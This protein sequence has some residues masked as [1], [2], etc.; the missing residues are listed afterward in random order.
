[1]VAIMLTLNQI[2][3]YILFFYMNLH[4]KVRPNARIMVRLMAPSKCSQLWTWKLF[5]HSLDYMVFG[6]RPGLKV[7]FGWRQ[8]E[9]SCFALCHKGNRE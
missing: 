6:A 3:D 7:S 5:A 1:M 9:N 8:S 4:F 2:Q